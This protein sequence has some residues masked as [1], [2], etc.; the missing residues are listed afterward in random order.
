MKRLSYKIQ[1][2]YFIIPFIFF[3]ITVNK[4]L[5]LGE[6]HHLVAKRYHQDGLL[7][8]D[9]TEDRVRGTTGGS[10][11][12]LNIASHMWVGGFDW[13]RKSKSTNGRRNENTEIDAL[14]N[15]FIGIFNILKA[16]EI[17]KDYI[18]E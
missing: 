5:I 9:G 16:T 17:I 2:V 12:T 18:V 7:E 11:R 4:K 3:A 6:W 13:K 1:F 15:G 14:S 8:L 10:L